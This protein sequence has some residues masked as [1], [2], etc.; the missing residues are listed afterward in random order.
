M[1]SAAA[2]FLASSIRHRRD[3]LRQIA[4]NAKDKRLQVN[5][6]INKNNDL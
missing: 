5:K 1:I 3:F 6:I 2:Y 4:L